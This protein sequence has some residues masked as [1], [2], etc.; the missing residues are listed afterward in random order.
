[1][2]MEGS[3]LI[4][5][6]KHDSGLL[7]LASKLIRWGEHLISKEARFT[8]TA[9][10]TED[11]IV[12][13]SIGG[14]Q[15]SE[16]VKYMGEGHITEVLTPPWMDEQKAT[17]IINE[18]RKYLGRPYGYIDLPI[19]FIDLAAWKVGAIEHR[20]V[21]TEA[22]NRKLVIVCSELVALSYWGGVQYEF[23]DR[24]GRALK[25]SDVT[26]TDIYLTAGREKW[27]MERL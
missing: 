23:K 9:I 10:I 21:V 8:H 1:M 4:T 15:E 16:I 14:V 6:S 13:A 20:G 12:E 18:S 2:G 24:K 22:L 26:P 5:T 17:A 11:G 27:Q 3:V 7:G 25:P 19:Y